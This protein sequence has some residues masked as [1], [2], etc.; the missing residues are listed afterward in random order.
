MCPQNS[1]AYMLKIKDKDERVVL[2]EGPHPILW[3]TSGSPVTMEVGGSELT[4][5]T[6]YSAEISVHTLGGH[7]SITFDIGKC[8]SILTTLH[9]KLHIYT[10]MS[11]MGSLPEDLYSISLYHVCLVTVNNLLT[12]VGWGCSRMYI[13]SDGP[14]CTQ[15]L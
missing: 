9:M 8:D 13:F 15:I 7:T 12:Q 14:V 4:R 10:N 5:N 2:I 6:R 1:A 3:N 11:P